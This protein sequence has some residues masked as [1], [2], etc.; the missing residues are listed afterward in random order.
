MITILPKLH[1]LKAPD[2][3]VDVIL[4]H[5]EQKKEFLVK[6]NILGK[7]KGR[8]ISDKFN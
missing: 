8:Q 2:D 4:E 5:I 6:E 1:E 3:W 7:R